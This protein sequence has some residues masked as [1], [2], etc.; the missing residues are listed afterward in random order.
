[1]YYDVQGY[2][3]YSCLGACHCGVLLF[4]LFSTGSGYNEGEY[5]QTAVCGMSL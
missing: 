1:M 4:L 5:L 3:E 2:E